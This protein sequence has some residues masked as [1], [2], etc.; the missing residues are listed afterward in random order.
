MVFLFL[1]RRNW[2][3]VCY[4][5]AY[6]YDMTKAA[7]ELALDSFGPHGELCHSGRLKSAKVTRLI[8]T[9]AYKN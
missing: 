7:T 9:V 8:E 2:A 4:F 5:Q 6:P 3:K 1:V